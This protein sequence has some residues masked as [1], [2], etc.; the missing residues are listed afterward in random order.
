MSPIQS[1]KKKEM[2]IMTK[3]EGMTIEMKLRKRPEEMSKTEITIE[4]Q[5]ERAE[6]TMTTKIDKMYNQIH[7][8]QK[9]KF[10]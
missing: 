6:D 4:D 3:G 2:R 7:I 9:D 5:T 1:T 10:R 8:N